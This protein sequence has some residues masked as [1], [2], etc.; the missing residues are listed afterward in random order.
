[1]GKICIEEGLKIAFPGRD[2]EF[3]AGVEI[4]MLATLMAMAISE[5]DRQVSRSNIEQARVLSDS[6]GYY[7]VRSEC[8]DDGAVRVTFSNR[9]RR[10][11]LRVVSSR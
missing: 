6:L 8:C 2:A 3:C 7:I 10:P 4:G 1:M 9:R 11:D 5:F